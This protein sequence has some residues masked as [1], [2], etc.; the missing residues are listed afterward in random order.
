[1]RTTQTRLHVLPTIIII[2][3]IFHDATTMLKEKEGSNNNN[4][5]VNNGNRI[6]VVD[7]KTNTVVRTKYPKC[8]RRCQL[9]RLDK[10][11]GPASSNE[12]QTVLYRSLSCFLS[13]FLSLSIYYFYILQ[14]YAYSVLVSI[15]IC[16]PSNKACQ[17][18]LHSIALQFYSIK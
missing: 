9:M 2:I 6:F 5:T 4:N 17:N 12:E 7:T 10:L 14:R 1:M 15:K 18:D 16:P 8:D 3:D 11:H 13:F